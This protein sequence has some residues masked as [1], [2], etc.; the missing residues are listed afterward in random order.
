MA[1]ATLSE[2]KITGP[3][4]PGVSFQRRVIPNK[5]GKIMRSFLI[6]SAMAL[7]LFATA[8]P[9]SA[10][11]VRMFVRHE[12]TDYAMWRK[13]YDAFKPTQKE[14]GVTAQSVYQSVD[15]PND[16]TVIHDF[17]SAEQAKAFV[18]SDKLKA[19]M[20]ASGVNGEPTI[21]YTHMAPGAMGKADPVRMF[22][23]HEV[24]DYAAWR[25]GFDA[26]QPSA[27]KM[28]SMSHAV[29]Q[30]TDNPNDILVTHDFA[31]AG[32]AKALAGSAELKAAMQSAGVK[33]KPQIWFTTQALK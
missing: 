18:A 15:D 17:K 16:V 11:D 10:A 13:S 28:G 5:K 22:V 7:G 20:Q 6:I 2:W 1:I 32:K 31:S 29:Y 8:V 3:R 30:A 33:G 27:E 24:A 23:H 25:K 19:A 4:C 9:A 26:F 12:V 14:M 21:V